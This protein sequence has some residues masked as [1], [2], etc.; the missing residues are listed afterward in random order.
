MKRFA[1]HYVWSSQTGFQKQFAVEILEGVVVRLFPLKEE[2][3]SVE[4]H[5]GVIL[6]LPEQDVS[7][8][9]LKQMMQLPFTPGKQQ[10]LYAH[11]FYPFDFI[12]MEPVDGTQHKL[13]L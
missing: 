1:A 4:W 10:P 13:L 3:E 2:I 11:L 9:G 7:L 5:P 8:A 12:K 6:L